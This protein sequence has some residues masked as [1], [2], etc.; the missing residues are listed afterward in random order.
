MDLYELTRGP[1]AGLALIV[2]VVGS[3]LRIGWFIGWGARTKVLSS[4]TATKDGLRAII[5]G[6]IPFGATYMRRKPVFTVITFFFH[7]G[8][9]VTP[10]FLLAHSVLLYESWQIEWWSL[11]DVLADTM[12]LAVIL[13][14]FFFLIRRLI[15]PEVKQVSRATDSWLLLLILICFLSAFLAYHQLGP[16]HPLLVLHVISGD[17]LLLVFPFSR[18][19]HMILFFFTRASLGSEFG[20]MVQGANW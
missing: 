13:A 15:V 20:P 4:T 6:L 8:V 5:R 19:F 2:F 9:F 16:Y 14:V 10:L 3:F 17:I 1:V 7:L 18:L 11:P 12:T